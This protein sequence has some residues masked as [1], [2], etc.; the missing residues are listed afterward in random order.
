MFSASTI[1][2]QRDQA[3][4]E[5]ELSTKANFIRTVH[6]FYSAVDLAYSNN[7]GGSL[8]GLN[9]T[10]LHFPLDSNRAVFLKQQDSLILC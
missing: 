4:R 9:S 10:K 3:H 5:T 6:S 8:E 7:M 1:F 2:K